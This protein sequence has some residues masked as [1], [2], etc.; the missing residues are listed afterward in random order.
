MSRF[1]LNEYGKDDIATI[2]SS[3]CIF[4]AEKIIGGKCVIYHPKSLEYKLLQSFG[5]KRWI[6]LNNCAQIAG[7]FLY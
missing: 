6:K 5:Q 3:F 1:L 7:V 2:L 4:E